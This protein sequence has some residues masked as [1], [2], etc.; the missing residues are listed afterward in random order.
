[1]S[2]RILFEIKDQCFS[3]RKNDRL[4]DRTFWIRHGLRPLLRSRALLP[5]A[6]GPALCFLSIYHTLRLANRTTPTSWPVTAIIRLLSFPPLGVRRF[7]E[8]RTH[9]PRTRREFIRRRNSFFLRR[10]LKKRMFDYSR[11]I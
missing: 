5:A 3:E 10:K 1:M 7:I 2:V 8:T 9:I 11:N 6:R 4:N